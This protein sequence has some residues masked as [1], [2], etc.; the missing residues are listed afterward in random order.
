M[1][2][3]LVRDVRSRW[4]LV[5]L[6]A[7]MMGTTGCLARVTTAS[8]VVVEEPVVEVAT[9]PVTIESYPRHHYRGAYVYLVDGRWY[10]RASGRWVVYRTEP[11]A[12]VKVRMGYEA[13][14]GRHHRPQSE[15]ASPTPHQRGKK[16]GHH[17]H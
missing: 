6:S 4:T 3:G 2:E 9:V 12:L 13:K 14:L 15:I 10:Y 11:Q 7:L 17:K 1:A 8:A 16:K 5:G